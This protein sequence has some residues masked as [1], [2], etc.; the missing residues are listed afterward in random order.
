M[1]I[2]LSL[3]LYIYIYIQSSLK[4]SWPLLRGD[5]LAVRVDVHLSTIYKKKPT[6][7]KT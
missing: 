2:H 1:Y 3:S 4:P 7:K 5:G 6:Q